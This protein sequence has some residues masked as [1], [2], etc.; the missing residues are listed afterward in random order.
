[1]S[2]ASKKHEKILNDALKSLFDTDLFS[3]IEMG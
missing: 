2:T 1:M 3:N